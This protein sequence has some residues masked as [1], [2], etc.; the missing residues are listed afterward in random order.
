MRADAP[1]PGSFVPESI[2]SLYQASIDDSLWQQALR[3]IAHQFGA[4]NCSV[5]G[6]D[7]KAN[8]WLSSHSCQFF[9]D[10]W[11]HDYREYFADRSPMRPVLMR[12]ENV[13]R[14]LI[15]H[16]MVEPAELQRS[17]F[18]ND[19][20]AR[21]GVGSMMAT[22]FERSSSH[23][24]YLAL[25]RTHGM[26]T[27]DAASALALQA[28]LPHIRNAYRIRNRLSVLAQH[29]DIAFGFLDSRRQGLIYLD[30]E[31]RLLSANGE[32]T[33][34]LQNADSLRCVDGRIETVCPVDRDR[35]EAMI[36][37]ACR[38]PHDPASGMMFD[39]CG[40]LQVRRGDGQLTCTVCVIPVTG[41]KI[42]MAHDRIAAAIR[43]IPADYL[44]VGESRQ[45]PEYN[46]TP[47]ETRLA[48]LL[49]EG[50]PQK[51][52]AWQLGISTN[53]LSTQRKSLYRKVGVSRHYDLVR[54]LELSSA[55]RPSR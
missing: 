54:Q 27:F 49:V 43:I 18:Y 23:I 2:L 36:R 34:I 30:A 31:G 12:D 45:W 48:R 38:F 55:R 19:Y 25:H 32:A 21:F 20:W 33:R 50:I 13:G 22:V 3:Q 8:E 51:Q 10:A 14:V 6:Y 17:E 29:E 26:P 24:A 53:T 42:F 5:A 11:F 40:S 46:L 35:F 41:R 28:L 15:S 1:Q 39:P 9:D 47:A 37:R 4:S 44:V 52:A 16:A 7:T